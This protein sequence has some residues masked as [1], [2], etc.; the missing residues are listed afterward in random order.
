M[1]WTDA[2]ESDDSVQIR[3]FCRSFHNGPIVSENGIQATYV[4]SQ[5]RKYFALFVL[6]NL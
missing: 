4:K 6:I 3:I 2:I 5:S 1:K